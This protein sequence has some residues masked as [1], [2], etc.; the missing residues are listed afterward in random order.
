MLALGS[1]H[2]HHRKK[3]GREGK[4]ERGEKTEKKARKPSLTRER[5][6]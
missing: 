2:H 5:V 4:W 1:I 3:G 6:G